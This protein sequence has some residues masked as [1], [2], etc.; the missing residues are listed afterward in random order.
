MRTCKTCGVE[1][2]LSNFPR[3]VNSTGQTGYRWK[4]KPCRNAY[5]YDRKLETF[6]KIDRDTYDQMYEA[7]G[8]SCEI[9]NST[10]ALVVDHCHTTGGVR[11]LLCH[12]C[13]VALGHA[14]DSPVLLKRMIKYLERR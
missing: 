9:C 3:Y 8:G 6:Y 12:S 10:N 5:N 14:K 4:C 7:C 11:G 13:N 2:E 1:S